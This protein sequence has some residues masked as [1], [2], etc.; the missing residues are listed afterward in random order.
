MQ[1]GKSDFSI[2]LQSG[3]YDIFLRP[4]GLDSLGSIL[5]VEPRKFEAEMLKKSIRLEIGTF[6]TAS[7]EAVI[8]AIEAVIQE[9]G[10]DDSRLL[11]EAVLE[12]EAIIKGHKVE[13]F[14]VV[15]YPEKTR[16]LPSTSSTLTASEVAIGDTHMASLESPCQLRI[17]LA[18]DKEKE[19]RTMAKI[20][21]LRPSEGC[22]TVSL[23]NGL[24]GHAHSI[25]LIKLDGI[26]LRIAHFY[27]RGQQFDDSRPEVEVTQ[28]DI[29]RKVYLRRV[30]AASSFESP[31]SDFCGYFEAEVGSNDW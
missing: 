2:P 30:E 6:L 19:D 25:F 8:E 18:I 10:N 29:P 14:R 21:L 22:K 27:P 23:N 5:V 1:R 11:I 31:F 7:Y 15:L 3:L 26:F 17:R 4:R 28:D 16:F 13:Y 9:E 20:F 12:T 24:D